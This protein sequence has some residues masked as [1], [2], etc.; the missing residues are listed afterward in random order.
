[1][2]TLIL[3]IVA[4]FAQVRANTLR[5]VWIEFA[6]TGRVASWA[7]VGADSPSRARFVHD[8]VVAGKL[9]AAGFV[10]HS[11]SSRSTCRA[12][13]PRWPRSRSRS[14]WLPHRTRRKT[15][16]GKH[17]SCCTRYACLGCPCELCE[18]LLTCVFTGLHWQLRRNGSLS[19]SSL[20]SGKG[21][22]SW[23]RSSRACSS[24]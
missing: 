4:V 18:L 17:C 2:K 5:N 15:S 21:T 6:T 10:F 23:M 11:A 14:S 24:S 8:A 1:M 3:S 13:C 16:A 20:C 12:T 7:A 22:R 19:I 9:T